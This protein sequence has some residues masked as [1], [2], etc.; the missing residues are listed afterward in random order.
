MSPT[1]G[2]GLK[3]D[4]FV[5]AMA[6]P[7]AG[8]WFEVH[9]ENYMVAG[10]PRLAMLE[11]ARAARP[12]SMHG[13]GLSLAGAAAPNRAHLSAL[14]R[15][16][17][18]FEPFL[19]SEHLAWSRI[20]M[21]CVPDLLPFPRTDEALARLCRNIDIVQSTLG[22]PILIENPSHYLALEGHEWSET[23]VLRA[24]VQRTGCGLL[25][26]VTNVA[27]SAHNLGFD[28]DTYFT[29]FPFDAVGEIHLAGYSHDSRSELLIDGHNAPVSADIW[30]LYR[31]VIA[32]TGPC[33]TLIERDA[34]LPPFAALLAERDQAAA[35]MG[36]IPHEIAHA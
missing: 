5:D 26:D 22:R 16:V 24:L 9:P 7:A 36:K 6:S 4:H 25:L 31:D 20:G 11:A 33:P 1:V 29:D 14:K 15:L 3:A 27:V 30:S 32:Q 17:D 8:L 2:I 28:A 13:V 19:V 35:M 34:L 10:G 21:H 23:G 18:R 12:V